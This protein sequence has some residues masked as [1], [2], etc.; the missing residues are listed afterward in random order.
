MKLPESWTK[1]TPLSKALALV[2]FAFL[3][4]IGF[5][6]GFIYS[7]QLYENQISTNQQDPTPTLAVQSGQSITIYS[8]PVDHIDTPERSWAV[9]K[10]YRLVGNNSPE[11]IIPSIGKVG[12]YP[13]S[14]VL[15]PDKQ[16]LLINLESKFALFDLNT[17]KIYKTI[18]L[19]YGNYRGVNFSPDSKK[20]FIWDQ[21][22]AGSDKSY[23]AY[24][25]DLTTDTKSTLNTNTSE[26]IS[27]LS[28]EKWR[29][30]DIVILSQPMGDYSVLWIY[31][32]N[33]NSLQ[34]KNQMFGHLSQNGQIMAVEDSQVNDSCNEY[35]GT[36]IG[37]YKI[38]NPVTLRV[39]DQLSGS[40][41][42]VSF[43]A[44]KPDG[45][46]I[47]FSTQDTIDSST[48][49]DVSKCTALY[50]QQETTLKYYS[51][52]IQGQIIPIDDYMEII[53]SWK[54]DSTERSVSWGV[55]KNIKLNLNL[56]DD[57]EII[58]QYY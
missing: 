24:I 32:L 48:S 34:N 58:Y 56:K 35:S 22:Y 30:D 11:V 3:P 36:D 23:S 28:V 29:D 42:V 21:K 49:A 55:M 7:Q 38:V 37:S 6:F 25:Y 26:Q 51:K 44:I 12:E 39:V 43:I 4:F 18:V 50:Q 15:S 5:Y 1:V 40:G 14:Y 53:K 19:D 41:K 31:D 54:L 45:K 16:T 33:T 52:S 17:K 8:E 13:S 27:S 10:L 47:L 46:E 9:E 20:L 57:F 2:L